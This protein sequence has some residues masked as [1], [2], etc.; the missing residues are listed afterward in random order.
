M[1]RGVTLVEMLIVLAVMGLLASWAVP[2]LSAWSDWIAVET[3][4]REVAAFY[5]AARFA[6]AQRGTRIRVQF[7]P[8]SLRATFEGRR[9]SLFRVRAG[10]LSRG[11]SLHASQAVV[12]IGSSGYGW[13]AG[14]TTLV[15]RR[16]KALD[17][18]IISRLGRVRWR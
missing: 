16:G 17:S 8:D 11:V 2:K 18:I 7:A 10:P 4:S 6:A 12:R 15:L 9:D 1:R 13:G 3:A 5:S 14:N